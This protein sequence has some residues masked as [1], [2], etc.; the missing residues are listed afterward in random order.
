L[1]PFDRTDECYVPVSLLLDPAERDLLDEILRGVPVSEW[2]DAIVDHALKNG[3][4]ASTLVKLKI[5][6]WF[7]N[8]AVDIH[9]DDLVQLDQENREQFILA[10]R[11]ALDL[12][13][14][15]RA[16]AIIVPRGEGPGRAG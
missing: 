2:K 3:L 10:M 13:P 12:P 16:V 8:G 7:W 14:N 5:A 1:T 15:L 6:C 4:A 11:A 9:P